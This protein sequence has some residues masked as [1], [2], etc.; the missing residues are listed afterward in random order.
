[1]ANPFVEEKLETREWHD[2]LGDGFWRG[3]YRSAAFLEELDRRLADPATSPCPGYQ[4]Q[5]DSIG[6]GLALVAVLDHDD[7]LFLPPELSLAAVHRGVTVE[8]LVGQ[9]RGNLLDPGKGRLPPGSVVSAAFHLVPELGFGVER[10]EH[11][12][13]MALAMRLRNHAKVAVLPILKRELASS[14]TLR[15]LRLARQNPAPI[16][17]VVMDGDATDVAAAA[18]IRAVDAAGETVL[19]TLKTLK[20]GIDR[21]RSRQEPVIFHF[22]Q[23]RGAGTDPFSAIVRKILD[24][25]G[26]HTEPNLL[27]QV[28]AEIQYG[29]TRATMIPLPPRNTVIQDVRAQLDPELESQWR[30]WRAAHGK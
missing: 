30:E 8:Q 4:S 7:Y 13:G 23:T 6:Q 3:L 28:A 29:I 2:R 20:N 1:M 10:L 24:K 5:R 16:V 18:G 14:A 21:V 12:I 22:T 17:F 26:W 25:K 27:E 9:W 15:L 19:D 11:G